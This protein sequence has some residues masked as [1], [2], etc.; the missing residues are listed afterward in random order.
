MNTL[1]HIKAFRMSFGRSSRTQEFLFNHAWFTA[2]IFRLI[3]CTTNLST[4]LMTFFSSHFFGHDEL[5]RSL[6]VDVQM[7]GWREVLYQTKDDWKSGAPVFG[8]QSAAT[9]STT[10]MLASSV[11]LSDTGWY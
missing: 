4:L 3:L 10:L 7:S 5:Y 8:E 6:Y 11:I 9:S 2:T 1:S